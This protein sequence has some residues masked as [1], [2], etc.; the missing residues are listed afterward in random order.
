MSV[1]LFTYTRQAIGLSDVLTAFASVTGEEPATAILYSPERCYLAIFSKG[2]LQGHDG[3]PL[4][5]TSVFEVRVF[6]ETAELRWLNDPGAEQR[7]RAVILT[8]TD[9]SSLLTDWKRSE[10]RTV[11]DGKL[12][13]TY[14]LWGEGTDRGMSNGWS[15]LATA[16]IGALPVPLSNVDRKQRVLLHSIEYLIEEDEHGNVIVFDERLCKLEVERG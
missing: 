10:N 1:P 9:Y 5:I 3:Q 2:L 16:R 14:L 4:D 6:N 15:E 13:Q 7:H 12:D 8:E 11:E